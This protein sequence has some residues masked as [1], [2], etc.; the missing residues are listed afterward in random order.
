MPAIPI[1][2][3]SL[4]FTPPSSGMPQTPLLPA[5]TYAVYRPWGRDWTNGVDQYR[6]LGLDLGGVKGV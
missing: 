1:A 6:E 3:I 5:V 2:A 4:R